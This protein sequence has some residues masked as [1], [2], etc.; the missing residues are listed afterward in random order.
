MT[1]TDLCRMFPPPYQWAESCWRLCLADWRPPVVYT[2]TAHSSQARTLL[3]HTRYTPAQNKILSSLNL[4]LW[5]LICLLLLTINYRLNVHFSIKFTIVLW[6]IS[7]DWLS[8]K[9]SLDTIIAYLRKLYKIK[10]LYCFHKTSLQYT[11]IIERLCKTLLIN[12]IVYV[13]LKIPVNYCSR[14]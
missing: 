12:S 2:G 7:F 11:H 1:H 9:T 13:T 4:Q 6:M 14:L 8:L 10:L 5:I 3:D